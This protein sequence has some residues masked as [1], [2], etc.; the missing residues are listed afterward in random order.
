MK[1]VEN[2]YREEI[3]ADFESIE[4]GSKISSK[5]IENSKEKQNCLEAQR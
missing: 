2:I 1:S 3:A 5:V 4:K